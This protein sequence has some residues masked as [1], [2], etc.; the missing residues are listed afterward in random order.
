ML[1]TAPSCQAG[2]HLA[3]VG[4]TAPAFGCTYMHLMP[5]CPGEGFI[6]PILFWHPCSLQVF[7]NQVF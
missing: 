7:A 1:D 3:A 6:V 2:L 5:A 4:L